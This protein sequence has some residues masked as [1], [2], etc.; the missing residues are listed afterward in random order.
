MT[1]SF[2]GKRPK[3]AE[4]S[5][6]APG[7]VIIGDVTLL[8]ES[9]IWFHSVIRADINR[10]E[11][12]EQTNIQDG[13]LLHVTLAHPLIVGKRVTVGHGVILHGCTIGD[14]CLIAMGSIVLDGAIVEPGC[15]IGAGA[16]VP[17]GMVVPESSLV[18]GSPAKVIRTI[19]PEDRD[20]I[21]K[22]W[23][24]YVDYSARYKTGL[25]PISQHE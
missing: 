14:D 4:S 19:R 3:I 1:F 15:L 18:L 13:C 8:D 11:I 10:I 21:Q 24:N 22:G 2:E 25:S 6:I 9:S 5:Y 17:P 20:R 16:L 7:V 12:G 23:Q